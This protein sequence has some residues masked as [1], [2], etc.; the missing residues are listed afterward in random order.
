MITSS[1]SQTDIRSIA[2]A[3]ICFSTLSKE[4][5]TK[6]CSKASP[7]KDSKIE[8]LISGNNKYKEKTLGES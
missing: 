5:K 6:F 7:I 4:E 8:K 1:P 2:F 3:N